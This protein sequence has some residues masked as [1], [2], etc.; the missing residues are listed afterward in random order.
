[1]QLSLLIDL[2]THF[3]ER[4]EVEEAE[5]LAQSTNGAIYSWKTVGRS[6]WLEGGYS[7]IDVLGIVVL[8]S[9]LPEYID[10]PDDPPEPGDELFEAIIDE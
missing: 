9:S 1:M 10:M 2:D 6:N 7:C 5:S 3:F 4:D 8:P